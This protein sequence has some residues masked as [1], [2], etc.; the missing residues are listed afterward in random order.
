M[1]SLVVIFKCLEYNGC[2]WVQVFNLHYFL[3]GVVVR[4]VKHQVPTLNS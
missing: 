4:R 3:H 2:V 1:C